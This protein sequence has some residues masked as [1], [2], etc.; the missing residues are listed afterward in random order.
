MVFE[1]VSPSS[2]EKDLVELAGLY[3]KAGVEEYWIADARGKKLAFRILVRGPRAFRAQ[4][5][6]RGWISS[7][8]WGRSFKLRRTTD[9]V[10]NPDFVLDSRGR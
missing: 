6:V 5:P 1:A 3:F 10:G 2:T 8:V 4:A 7:R 9:R